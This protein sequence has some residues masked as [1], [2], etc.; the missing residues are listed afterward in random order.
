LERQSRATVA[1]QGSGQPKAGYCNRR[2]AAAAAAA[3]P[4]P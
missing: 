3:T 4:E 2:A 1:L